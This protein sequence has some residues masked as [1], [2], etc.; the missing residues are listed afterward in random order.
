MTDLVRRDVRS[1]RELPLALYQIQTKF[2]DEIR[3]RFGL[4]RAREFVMMDAY[5]FHRDVGV[6]TRPTGTCTRPTSASS[7]AW[8]G[9]PPG[10]RR[11]RRH[12]R[13]M[14]T[15]STPGRVGEDESPVH[16]CDY[17]ANVE[18]ASI[19]VAG[20]APITSTTTRAQGSG[21]HAAPTPS[22]KWLRSSQ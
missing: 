19:G 18:M 10:R 22:M 3:P 12:G 7:S 8:L 6:G 1:Y 21:T 4:L 17:A 5:S 2:R 20:A 13:N 15:N 9:M 11:D 14:A 16:Q